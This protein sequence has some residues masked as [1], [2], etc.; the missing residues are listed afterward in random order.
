MQEEKRKELERANL[1]K[2]L[3]SERAYNRMMKANED[4]K[5]ATWKKVQAKNN[6]LEVRLKDLK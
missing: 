2:A 6:K 5:K 3:A 4:F 1:N